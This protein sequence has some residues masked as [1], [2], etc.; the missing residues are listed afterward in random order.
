MTDESQRSQPPDR[1]IYLAQL[2]HERSFPIRAVH[3]TP[4]AKSV[5]PA[6][7]TL[8]TVPRN[9][10]LVVPRRR[11]ATRRHATNA[12]RRWTVKRAR[13]SRPS[14]PR[15]PCAAWAGSTR[16]ISALLTLA[17]PTQIAALASS[18]CRV[19]WARCGSANRRTAVRMQ[20][21]RR[22]RV[23]HASFSETGAARTRVQCAPIV[24]SN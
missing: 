4:T 8:R 18:V 11:A 15:V 10:L 3:R 20:T 17:R 6:F 21:A 22:Q 7:S 14:L 12:A 23:A 24:L 16:S 5:R 2:A 13:A 1:R 9:A 19:A